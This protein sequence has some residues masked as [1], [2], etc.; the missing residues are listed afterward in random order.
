MASERVFEYFTQ[1]SGARM[2]SVGCLVVMAP[3]AVGALFGLLLPSFAVPAAV[4]T[5][6]AMW[7]RSRRL[8]ARPRATLCIEE[9]RLLVLDQDSREIL[10]VRLKDL[11]EVELDTKTI[12]RVE[13]NLSGGA[14][15][16]FRALHSKVG[17]A[18]DVSR[19]VL[20][21]SKRDV[22][23]SEERMSI[24]YTTESFGKLRRF[25]RNHGWLPEAE[26]A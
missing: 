17:S 1:P 21:T 6:V 15:P 26:R 8:V 24:S 14:L 4:L 3:A 2:N 11:L 7:W 22:P 9:S 20:V 13:G 18:S 5:G 16:Q 12:Q 19:I 10:R 25:L 23:L